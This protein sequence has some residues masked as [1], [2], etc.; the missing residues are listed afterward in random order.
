[1]GIVISIP[2]AKSGTK[3]SVI[4]TLITAILLT[5][6]SIVFLLPIF[7]SGDLEVTQRFSA[8]SSYDPYYSDYV[9]TVTGEVKNTTSETMYDV[10]FYVTVEN[11]DYYAPCPAITIDEILP[12]EIVRVQGEFYGDGESYDGIDE[13]EYSIN[14][15]SRQ[16]LNQGDEWIASLGLGVVAVVMWIIFLISLAQYKK[17]KNQVQEQFGGNTFGGPVSTN[18][19]EVMSNPFATNPQPTTQAPQAARAQTC[20]YCGSKVAVTD[21]KCPGCGAKL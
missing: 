5:I 6:L 21:G 14:G 3:A 4:S 1:M 8:R 18:D 17:K 2:R 13:I 12:G 16:T 15:G 11:D 20:P 10:K 9:V 7:G 19:G